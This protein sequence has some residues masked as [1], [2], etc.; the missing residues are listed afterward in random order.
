MTIGKGRARRHA[1][2]LLPYGYGVVIIAW[3]LLDRV[4][5]FFQGDSL[6]YLMT[7]T[8]I[9][10]PDSFTLRSGDRIKISIAGIGMLENVV[11]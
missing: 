2:M 6:S 8:G 10:P 5:R 9:V 11:A 3:M 7:G 1:A 4:P